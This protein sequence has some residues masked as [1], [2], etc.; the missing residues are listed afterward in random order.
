QGTVDGGRVR[1]PLGEFDLPADRRGAASGDVLVGVRPEDF[2]DARLI[3]GKPGHTFDAPITLIE[4]L[5]SDLFAYFEYRGEE[6]Q[7]QELAEL[8]ADAGAADLP[9]VGG[10]T[11]AIARLEPA[12]DIRAD[13]TARLWMDTSKVHLFDPRTGEPLTHRGA[14]SPPPA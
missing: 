3:G 9:H 5:G 7:T 11:Q 14:R 4:S 12:S 10:A 13:T 6:V 1:F 8:A 2:E